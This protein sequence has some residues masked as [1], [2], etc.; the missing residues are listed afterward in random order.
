MRFG[1]KSQL[2]GPL[3][4]KDAGLAKHPEKFN[5]FTNKA[6]TTHQ[7]FYNEHERGKMRVKRVRKDRNEVCL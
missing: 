5:N 2:V 7:G 1:R 6:E 3:V 4:A